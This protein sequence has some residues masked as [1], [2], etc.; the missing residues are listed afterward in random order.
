MLTRL[1]LRL[2]EL[3]STAT[4]AR[5]PARAQPPRSFRFEEL[6]ARILLSADLLPGLVDADDAIVQVVPH[7]EPV[8]HHAAGETAG[9]LLPP[10]AVMARREIVIID[11]HV[12][13]YQVFIDD[14]LAN[15]E[16]LRQI[17]VFVLDAD[18]D[19]IE[20]ISAILAQ[21]AG[22]DAV[23]LIAHGSDG[24]IDVG[25]T[26]VDF[27]ALFGR[28]ASFVAWGQSFSPDGDLLL[29]GCN[30]A[31][32]RYGEIFVEHLA[33]LTGADV[34]ASTNVTGSV[35]RGGDWVLEY[36][37]GAIETSELPS[38]ALK[39]D[40]GGVL[41]VTTSGQ[42]TSKTGNA[43]TT[44]LTWSHRVD[45]GDD[46]AL[47]VEVSIA[48]EASTVT[49]V[50]FGSQSLSRAGRATGTGAGA[51]E[52]WVLADPNVGTANISLTLS[53]AVNNI[54]AGASTFYGVDQSS[55]TGT[56]VGTHG[57]SKIASAT[58]ASQAGDVVIAGQF[59]WAPNELVSNGSGQSAVWTASVAPLTGRATQA[60]GAASVTMTTTARDQAP[61]VMGAV[62]IKAVPPPNQAPSGSDVTVSTLQDVPYILRAS[63][64]GFSDPDGNQ[65]KAVK[66]SQL[67]GAGSLTLNGAPV[68]QGQ[69]VQAS[70]INAGKLKF[71]P[72]AQA[73]GLGYASFEF[74]VQD[75]GGTASGGVDTDPTAR[76]F[77]IDVIATTLVVDT[78]SDTTGGNVSSTSALLASKGPDNRISLR[79]AI[80]A[81]NNTNTGGVPIR[82]LFEI[83]GNGVHTITLGSKLPGIVRPVIIDGTSDG[84]FGYNGG[85]PAIILDVNGNAAERGLALAAGSS[86]ST[87][88]GLLITN[89]SDVGILIDLGSNGNLVAGNYIGALAPSG[90]L[91]VGSA[92]ANTSASYAA[93]EINSAGNIIGGS[94][95]ADRNVISPKINRDTAAVFFDAATAQNNVLRGNYIGTNAAGTVAVSW[96]FDG[97][98]LQHGASNNVIGGPGAN[99]YNLIVTNASGN[100]GSGI[101]ASGNT[102][103]NN[104]VQGN[105]FGIGSNGERLGTSLHAIW[106]WG[107]RSW[108]IIDNHMAGGA[109]AIIY[110][111]SSS[112]NSV[113]RGNVLG[114]DATGTADWG[115]SKSG[116]QIDNSNGNQIGG[117]AAGQGNTIAFSNG[118]NA[119]HD[120]ITITG[121]STGN[122]ILGNSIHSIKGTG[123]G[124]DLGPDGVTGNDAGDGDTGPNN[125]QNFPELNPITIISGNTVH[126]N[127]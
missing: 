26:Q 107:A 108:Q 117:T 50:Q 5:Q 51:V 55:P 100:T 120:G 63:D 6:E 101:Y 73:S 44:G 22:L 18:Q 79:E 82:I 27:Q 86:G 32:T 125:L 29:Y 61:W 90:E 13:D 81:A 23:H 35:A 97:I 68:S 65:L 30:V 21:Q 119:G 31:E 123:L 24:S 71:T 58:V 15:S 77:S 34:A 25:N 8:A 17:E 76:T 62:A 122:A 33:A 106:L 37:T 98:I 91:L 40:W 46:R 56:F 111:Y 67:P 93:L 11:P 89:F 45:N 38:A 53:M 88:R 84:S 74:Q 4:S 105:Y 7:S 41:A 16:D 60:A 72:A 14:I 43:G 118:T 96:S 64:F 2:A 126:L 70:D 109:D 12:S 39:Q 78:I 116:I 85:R 115:A 1:L 99:D 28:E 49:S 9:R 20:Q 110:L 47:F 69:F 48:G 114:T 75:N 42:Q 57:D 3:R 102:T 10:E 80:L 127:P 124:I 52:I 19:G 121:T 59:W 83:P 95:E 112:N 54:A 87:I 113:V 36:D 94:A 103:S 92:L 104:T 66:I